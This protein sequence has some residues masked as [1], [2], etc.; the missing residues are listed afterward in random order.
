M[1]NPPKTIRE[2]KRHNYG[3]FKYMPEHCAYNVFIGW[4]SKQCSRKNG[5]G[6]EGLYC[7]QH[8]SIIEHR[9]QYTTKS[10]GHKNNSWKISEHV[11]SVSTNRTEGQIKLHVASREILDIKSWGHNTYS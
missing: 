7:K 3:M 6:I 5:H 2:A 10:S 1:L 4:H 8:E 9:A 11:Q